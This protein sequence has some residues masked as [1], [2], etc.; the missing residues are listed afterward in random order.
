MLYTK[1]CISRC[2]KYFVQKDKLCFLHITLYMEKWLN[3]VLTFLSVSLLA[4]GI[5]AHLELAFPAL[6]CH[7]HTL[8]SHNGESD[9]S[10]IV[11]PEIPELLAQ[12]SQIVNIELR[13]PPFRFQEPDKPAF[14]LSVMALSNRQKQYFCHAIIPLSAFE[15]H[16]IGFPFLTFW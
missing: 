11:Q 1:L 12:A 16:D 15:S 9:F 8:H 2:Q 10:R 6:T 7:N 14:F 3:I 13:T 5:P 4:Y